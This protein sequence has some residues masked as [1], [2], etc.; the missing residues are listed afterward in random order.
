VLP[1][2][3]LDNHNDWSRWFASGSS[4]LFAVSILVIYFKKK[5]A[6]A[7]RWE[8]TNVKEPGQIIMIGQSKTGSS[9]II[10]ITLFSGW[11]FSS[12]SKLCKKML[13]QNHLLN[14]TSMF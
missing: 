14:Q 3:L 8:T 9:H 5:I 6:T 12:L 11:S 13:G 10:F 4:H 2:F 7:N 1:V